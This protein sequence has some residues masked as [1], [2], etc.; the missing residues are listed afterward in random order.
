MPWCPECKN[1]YVDGVTVCADCGCELVATLKDASKEA[2][3]FGEEAKMNQLVDFL[4]YN[5]IFDVS[6]EF[7]EQDQVF[8]VFVAE[9]DSL[10][11]KKLAAV[12]IRQKELEKKQE[13]E[14][15]RSEE[16]TPDKV[17]E[18]VR[19]RVYEEASAK[20]QEFKSGAYTLL[21]VGVIGLIAVVLVFLDIIPM[22]LSLFS[23]YLT[24]GVMGVLFLIFIIMGISSFKTYKIQVGKAEKENSLKEELKKFCQENLTR[25][26][27][28]EDLVFDKEEGEEGFYFKRTEKMKAMIAETFLNLDDAYLEH[29]VDELYEEIFDKE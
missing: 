10:Q 22:H 6:V 20:A 13:L 14:A 7:D 4:K 29:F 8:E 21:V 12:F 5:D 1:E 2:I 16:D 3:A 18:P 23:K 28:D 15:E 24:C 25:E 26:S 19:A 27:I 9:E 11:A 17:E